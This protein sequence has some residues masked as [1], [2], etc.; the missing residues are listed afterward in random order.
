MTEKPLITEHVLIALKKSTGETRD[1]VLPICDVGIIEEDNGQLRI[2]LEA[3][4]PA[5]VDDA[6][7]VM[8]RYSDDPCLCQAYDWASLGHAG[9]RLIL[10]RARL[11]R[12]PS[13]SVFISEVKH[14]QGEL[15]VAER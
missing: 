13:L 3:D 1:L 2:L 9:L 11:E 7:Q 8:R 6:V 5:E 10:Q 15:W 4:L 14:F 12:W